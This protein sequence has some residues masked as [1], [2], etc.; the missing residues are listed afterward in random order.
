MTFRQYISSFKSIWGIL[1]GLALALSA[2]L[3]FT[4]LVPPWPDEAGVSAS[5]LAVVSCV[6]GVTIGYFLPFSSNEKRKIF[7]IVLLLLSMCLLLSY[8]Y[9]MSLRIVSFTQQVGGSEVVRRVVVGTVVLDNANAKKPPKELIELYGIDP[10]A[11]WT[12]RSVSNS[13]ICLL[14]SYMGFYLV[15]TCGLGLLQGMRRYD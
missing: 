11:S 3:K 12:L 4:P 15:L 10:S 2:I 5:A 6:V 8:L 13:R 7:G 14:S 1:S 9:S